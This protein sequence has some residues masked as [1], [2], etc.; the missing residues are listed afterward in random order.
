MSEL[1]IQFVPH[2][3]IMGLSSEARIKK[4][5]EIVKLDKIALVEGQLRK[6]EEAK[7]I[8]D[9]MSSINTKFKGIELAVI[10]PQNLQLSWLHKVRSTL[11]GVILGQKGGLTIVGPAT[12][13]REIKQDPEKIQLFTVDKKTGRK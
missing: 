7:L 5:I 3:E 13:V 11:A 2:A 6:E 1:T 4:L 9:T 12:V 8:A 10:Y